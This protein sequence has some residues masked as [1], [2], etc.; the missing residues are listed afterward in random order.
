MGYLISYAC[1]RNRIVMS[2]GFFSRCQFKE[3]W[4]RPRLGKCIRYG[5]ALMMLLSACGKETPQLVKKPLPVAIAKVVRRDVP[6]Y[7]DAFE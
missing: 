7:A 1:F 5:C 4:Q 3:S 6:I 2:F